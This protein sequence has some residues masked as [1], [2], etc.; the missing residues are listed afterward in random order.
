MIFVLI[1]PHT[2]S[3]AEG[4]AITLSQGENV[5]LVGS[6]TAGAN[7]QPMVIPLGSGI[8][9]FINFFK[10]FDFEGNDFSAGIQPEIFLDFGKESVQEM[11]RKL[12]LTGLIPLFNH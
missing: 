3:A 8:N 4:L 6:K 2:A 9:L 1:G 10:S 12:G 5:K 11:V 7:G